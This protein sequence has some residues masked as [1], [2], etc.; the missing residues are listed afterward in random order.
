MY[1]KEMEQAIDIAD[2]ATYLNCRT[3]F[4]CLSL[5]GLEINLHLTL[6]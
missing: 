1:S 2:D 4:E 6:D 5:K 3:C